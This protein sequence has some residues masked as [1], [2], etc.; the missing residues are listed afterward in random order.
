MIHITSDKKY[1]DG[2]NFNELEKMWIDKYESTFGLPQTLRHGFKLPEKP[3]IQ[4]ELA[5]K[6]YKMYDK[7]KNENIDWWVGIVGGEGVGKSTLATAILLEYCR[8]S[9]KDFMELLD[10]NVV[11]DDFEIMRFLARANPD[12]LFDFIWADEGANVFF[13]RESN[14][15]SRKKAMKCINAMRFKNYFMTICSVEIRQLD[16]IIRDHRLK[17]LI[18]VPK[19]GIYEYYDVDQ[20]RQL[21]DR[22]KG[23]RDMQFKW[24][25]VEPQLVGHYSRSESTEKIIKFLKDNYW[26]RMQMEMQQDV[27]AEYKKKIHKFEGKNADQKKLR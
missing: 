22:N 23:R 10:K 15:S 19:R 26:A 27:V 24:H 1:I 12:S 9:G 8:V 16:T 6:I 14:T 20:I 3:L 2:L 17:T 21:L 4:M 11:F 18:R 5:E 13:N 25:S 7:M